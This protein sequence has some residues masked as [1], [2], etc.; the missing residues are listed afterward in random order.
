MSVRG[1]TIFNCDGKDCQATH[2]VDGCNSYNTP[3]G[4]Y[5]MNVQVPGD[6]SR[7]WVKLAC[8]VCFAKATVVFKTVWG[9]VEK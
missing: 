4:W 9:F 1:Q 8:P 6:S 5:F 2:T 7:V 3:E